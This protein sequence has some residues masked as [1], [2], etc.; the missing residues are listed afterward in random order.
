MY[1]KGLLITVAAAAMWWPVLVVA[2]EKGDTEEVSAEAR[3]PEARPPSDSQ[4]RALVVDGK[5]AFD[6]SRLVP[7]VCERNARVAFEALGHSIANEKVKGEEAL[8]DPEVYATVD[9]GETNNPN[10]ATDYYNQSYQSVFREVSNSYATGVTGLLP[11]GA[12]WSLDLHYYDRN[13]DLIKERYLGLYENEYQ[14]VVEI[15]LR[16]PLLKNFGEDATLSKVRVAEAEREI[17][18]QRYRLRLMEMAGTAITSYW[19][20]YHA[21]RL[22]EIRS[23]SVEFRKK[24]VD[25]MDEKLRSGKGT[26]TEVLE[27]NAAV[28]QRRADLLSAEQDVV[29]ESNRLRDLLGLKRTEAEFGMVAV[30]VKPVNPAAKI[31]LKGSVDRALKNWPEYLIADKAV[32]Q[33]AIEADYAD[34]Q[35]LPQLDVK[36]SYGVAGLGVASTRSVDQAFSGTYPTWSVGLEVRRAISNDQAEHNA[37]AATLHKH[38]AEV[39]RTAVELAVTNTLDTK[40][41]KVQQTARELEERNHYVEMAQSILDAEIDRLES[42]KARVSDVI[43]KEVL[44]NEARVQE[45]KSRVE[46]EKAAAAVDLAEGVLLDHYGVQLKLAASK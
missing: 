35:T 14:S 4:I 8:Y 18:F 11:Y 13:N 1:K 37:S 42:G 21:Q 9:H 38:Q 41:R 7:L 27:A 12:H 24:I 43:D 6:L 25:I 10:T 33:A 15:T 20:L 22:Q 5:F 3:P 17:A 16:Q 26:R 2:Q 29:T 39:E 46:H 28:S 30:G 19:D 23:K 34:N 32:D 36:A 40:L 44:L 31:D 45:V